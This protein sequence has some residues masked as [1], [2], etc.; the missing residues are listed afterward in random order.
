[1]QKSAA[2]LFLFIIGLAGTLSLQSCYK[3]PKEGNA[4]IIIIDENQLRVPY[5]TVRLYQGDINYVNNSDY[6]GVAMFDNLLEVILTVEA[7]KGAKIGSGIARIKPDETI[8]EVVT[9]Y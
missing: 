6:D 8:T 2:F 9:I 4:R 3:E 5:A 7:K 1:M